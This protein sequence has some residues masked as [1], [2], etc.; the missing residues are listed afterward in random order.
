MRLLTS[1]IGLSVAWVSAAWLLSGC[2]GAVAGPGIEEPPSGSGASST[3]T[4]A[5]GSSSSVTRGGSSSVIGGPPVGP[6]AAGVACQPGSGCATA[7][8]GGA[9]SCAVSCNC[10]PAGAFECQSDCVDASPP[11]T[12]C[13][14]GAACSL[15]TGCGMGTAGGC[16]TSCNC[17]STG[18]LQ[19]NTTCPAVDAGC[20]QNELCIVGDHFDPQQ[21]RCVP[22]ACVSAQGGPCGGTI[23]NPCQC[24][25]GLVCQSSGPDVG[26]TCEPPRTCCPSGWQ[27][28]SCTDVDGGAGFNCHN[29]ALGCPSSTTCG[30]GCDTR[31][32]GTCPVCDPIPCPAGE[33]FDSSQCTCVSAGCTTAADCTGP[34]PSIC[35]LCADGGTSCA[36]WSCVGGQC[37]DAL[38]Q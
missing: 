33:V 38:C 23:A 28:Y 19:C 29:P 17:D 13:T 35:E 30:G 12:G 31:V 10:G 16:S 26:G 37:V 5:S 15:N 4:A 7:A 3:T 25:A 36:H 20:V 9:A 22:N 8:T 24:G 14:Q 18:H 6:C 34:L 1:T 2:S 27:L 21:C 32:T 11:P